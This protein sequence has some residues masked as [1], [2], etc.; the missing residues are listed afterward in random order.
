M[1]GLNLVMI[2]A[3]ARASSSGTPLVMAQTPSKRTFLQITSREWLHFL[4][5][6]QHLM[7]ESSQ[8]SVPQEHG[9]YRQKVVRPL[10]KDG[11]VTI[12][13]IPTWE[14]HPWPLP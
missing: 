5:G 9:Y 3:P 11:V 7:A 6:D 2:Q 14:A 1:T 12:H 8:T 10:M 13:P 4:A